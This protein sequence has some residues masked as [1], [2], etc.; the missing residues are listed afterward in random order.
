MTDK[1]NATVNKRQKLVGDIKIGVTNNYESLSNKPRINDV[2]LCG[3]KTFEELGMIECSNQ[4][5][6]EIFK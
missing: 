2:E 3:N 6:E 4:D 1:F 5:I